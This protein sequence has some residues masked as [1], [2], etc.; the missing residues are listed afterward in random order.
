[1]YA[2]RLD[3]LWE[4][5][6]FVI[7]WIVSIAL[8]IYLA[9]LLHLNYGPSIHRLQCKPD[10]KETWGKWIGI[11]PH[12]RNFSVLLFCFLVLF[13]YFTRLLDR[14][15]CVWILDYV[16]PYFL[17]LCRRH[18]I[19]VFNFLHHS[20]LLINARLGYFQF[21]RLLMFCSFSGRCRQWSGP[22]LAEE[23]SWSQTTVDEASWT[24]A[25]FSSICLLEFM[26]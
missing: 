5:I 8:V 13:S 12:C 24:W 23:E 9:T 16:G 22:A 26:F 18:D 6:L 4:L 20:R 14:H 7:H 17:L 1:M 25:D 10:K 19:A 3:Y 21:E 11:K 2:D 15:F